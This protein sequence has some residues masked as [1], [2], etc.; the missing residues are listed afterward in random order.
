MK[1]KNTLHCIYTIT[2][3]LILISCCKP[4]PIAVEL[5]KSD[6]NNA[7]NEAIQNYRTTEIQIREN[8]GFA[9]I[10]QLVEI[11]FLNA[12]KTPVLPVEDIIREANSNIIYIGNNFSTLTGFYIY[13][14][15]KWIYSYPTVDSI[16][17][18]FSYPV[19]N[20]EKNT[21]LTCFNYSHTAEFYELNIKIEHNNQI[22]FSSILKSDKSEISVDS[23]LKELNILY[24]NYNSNNTETATTHEELSITQNGKTF[25]SSNYKIQQEQTNSNNPHF[26]LKAR[27]VIPPLVFIT[28]LSYTQNDSTDLYINPNSYIKFSLQNSDGETFGNFLIEALDMRW[29]YTFF[30]NNGDAIRDDWFLKDLSKTVIYYARYLGIN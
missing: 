29:N 23:K 24:K 9:V 19:G 30:Y 6:A 21:R 4:K 2:T 25:A 11:G 14:N 1:S 8:A 5:A 13:D 3:I 18:N 7:V 22:I 15:G 27:Q 17:L 12:P 20:A 26:T 10:K 16:V 28:D